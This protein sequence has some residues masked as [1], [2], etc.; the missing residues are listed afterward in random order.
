MKA[1]ARIF[2]ALVLMACLVAAAAL[3]WLR[4]PEN[5]PPMDAIDRIVI[6]K[7]ARRIVL[8]QNGKALRRY[9]VALGTNPVGD[10]IRQGDNRT[11]EGIFRINRKNADSAFHLSLG[12][13]YPQP[14]DI[15]R[16]R[17]GGYD[18]GGDIMIH[19]QPNALPTDIVI[20]G[21]WTAGCIALPNAQIAAIFAATP[22]GT[23][24]EIRP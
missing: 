22:I 24:V 13:D 12:L 7:A 23:E 3:I 17:A 9:P 4:P 11:P 2:S 8:F 14:A 21:D 19:G 10:K 16:A 18:P 5:L 6:E 1:L 20:P 15:A